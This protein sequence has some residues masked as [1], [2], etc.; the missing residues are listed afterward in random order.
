M[1]ARVWDS[2]TARD[3]VEGIASRAEADLRKRTHDVI[4]EI[5]SEAENEMNDRPQEAEALKWAARQIQ[6]AL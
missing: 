5:F 1:S 6:G 4:A 2:K 3:F